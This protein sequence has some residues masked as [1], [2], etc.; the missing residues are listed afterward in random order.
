[1]ITQQD[2]ILLKFINSVSLV[3][4]RV[5]LQK[6]FYLLQYMGLNIDDRFSMHYYGPYSADLALRIDSL[7]SNGYIE[8][9]GSA[10]EYKYNISEPGKAAIARIENEH[11]TDLLDPDWINKFKALSKERV[12]DL[13]RAAT[14]LFWLDWGKNFKDAL[15]AS[16]LQKGKV[17]DS[18]LALALKIR[19]QKH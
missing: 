18:A 11:L 6:A 16:Q 14:I 5:R 19:G 4:G 17:P 7:V 13:E 3:R 15:K 10:R 12:S 2:Y 8:E 9:G 1:M